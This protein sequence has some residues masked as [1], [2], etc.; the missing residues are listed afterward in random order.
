MYIHKYTILHLEK[1]KEIWVI[2][3]GKNIN[4]CKKKQMM[5]N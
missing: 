2:A 3:T 5:S 4:N 1:E